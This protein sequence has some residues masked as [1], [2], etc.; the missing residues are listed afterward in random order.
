MS[1]IKLDHVTKRFDMV[2]TTK[3]KFKLLFK[4]QS[5][6]VKTFTALRGCLARDWIGR[7]R[8]TR[9]YQWIR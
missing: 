3:E 5:K 9:W 2:T 1:M 6:S 7:S 8:R 4:N